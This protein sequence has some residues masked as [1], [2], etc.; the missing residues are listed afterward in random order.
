MCDNSPEV[1][2]DVTGL[3]CP[4]PVLKA[5][6]RLET[7]VTGNELVVIATDPMSL[8]DMPHFCREQGHQLLS[9]TQQ[10]DT[11]SFRIRKS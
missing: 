10:N 5:K 4:L 3:L 1:R 2:L 8:I 9:A 7:M 6:K 11:I